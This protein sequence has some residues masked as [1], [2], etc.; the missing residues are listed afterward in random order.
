MRNS[1]SML[2]FL[3]GATFSS[4][5]GIAS[6]EEVTPRGPMDV[7]AVH[8][9][10]FMVEDIQ[11]KDKCIEIL[12]FDRS[13]YEGYDDDYYYISAPL[14]V[15]HPLPRARVCRIMRSKIDWSEIAAALD[16]KQKKHFEELNQVPS[17]IE[18]DEWES[19]TKP[20]KGPPQKGSTP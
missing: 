7:K 19:K 3:V 10:A 20:H 2:N 18:F 6:S 16:K 15:D 17:V 14:T 13:R 4:I 1:I 9:Q 11:N 12:L 5:A 8:F